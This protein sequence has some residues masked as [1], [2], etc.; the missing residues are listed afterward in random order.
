MNLAELLSGY[1]SCVDWPTAAFYK[2]LMDLFPQAKVRQRAVLSSGTAGCRPQAGGQRQVPSGAPPLGASHPGVN[3][4]S[5]CCIQGRHR[6]GF[7]TL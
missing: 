7:C 1:K 5:G 4:H 3:T 2:E 6:A